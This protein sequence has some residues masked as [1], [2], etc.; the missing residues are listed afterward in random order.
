[1]T[2]QKSL[3]SALIIG[4]VV[5]GANL[6]SAE[7][8]PTDNTVAGA[9]PVLLGN[10]GSP[11]TP[12]GFISNS[13]QDWYSIANTAGYTSIV[14]TFA[15]EGSGSDTCR[16]RI[17]GP[18]GEAVLFDQ[19]T[20]TGVNPYRR[21]YTISNPAKGAV[22][23]IGCLGNSAEGTKSYTLTIDPSPNVEFLGQVNALKDE[24]ERLELLNIKYDSTRAQLLK[25]IKQQKALLKKAVRKAEKTR[26]KALIAK[27][28]RNRSSLAVKIVKNQDIVRDLKA[29]LLALVRPS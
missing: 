17:L 25:K 23:S 15:F 4:M 12:S 2:H 18:N 7:N 5:V 28:E 6:V 29:E 11:V 1:M 19:L 16:L 14:I 21:S 22:Y 9:S 27:Y 13:D 3:A 24:I 10:N 26:I 8:E 20:D